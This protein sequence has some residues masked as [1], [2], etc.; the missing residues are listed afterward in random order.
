[1]ILLIFMAWRLTWE[2]DL[3]I[4]Y[5]IDIRGILVSNPASCVGCHSYANLPSLFSFSFKDTFSTMTALRTQTFIR[6][7]L[8]QHFLANTDSSGSIPLGTG[9]PP[10]PMPIQS[11]R[12]QLSPEPTS[13]W[14]VTLPCLSPWDLRLG[15]PRALSLAGSWNFSI[16]P[17]PWGMRLPW[18]RDAMKESV[19]FAHGAVPLLEDRDSDKEKRSRAWA[20]RVW[21]RARNT[22]LPRYQLKIEADN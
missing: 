1:M 12:P 13:R 17:V 16:R 11:W 5:E 9:L 20:S 14:S 4:G 6:K 2:G 22:P 10:L 18:G 8:N 15:P 21:A 7:T 19:F 3:G